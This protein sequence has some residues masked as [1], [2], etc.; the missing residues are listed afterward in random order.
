VERLIAIAPEPQ[1][2]TIAALLPDADQ[3]IAYGV[4]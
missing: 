3:V 1:R 4:P 2:S